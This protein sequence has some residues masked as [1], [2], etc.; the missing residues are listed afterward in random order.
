MEDTMPL[1]Q[2]AAHI[3]ALMAGNAAQRLEQPIAGQLL[4]CDGAE[5]ASEP[6]VVALAA[7]A[8]MRIAG[9][10]RYPRNSTAA[11]AN[12]VGGQIW[13]ALGLIEASASPTLASTK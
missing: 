5:V 4:R 1:E 8:A 3:Y 9:A 10:T 12:P 6:A 7:N 2:I 11:S 13:V